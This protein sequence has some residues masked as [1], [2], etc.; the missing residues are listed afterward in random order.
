MLGAAAASWQLGAGCR[1][2]MAFHMLLAAILSLFVATHAAP[3]APEK[4][5]T[6]LKHVCGADKEKSFAACIICIE[7]HLAKIQAH[8]CTSA[9]I[10]KFCN[11]KPPDP[12]AGYNCDPMLHQC[13]QPGNKTKAECGK[14]CGPGPSPPPG[15]GPSPSPMPKG[16]CTTALMRDCEAERRNE[17]AC[18]ACVDKHR[19]SLLKENCT[20]KIVVEFCHATP[21]PSPSPP[22]PPPGP[23]PGPSPGKEKCEK[24]LKKDCGTERSSTKECEACVDAHTK[25]LQKDGCTETDVVRYCKVPVPPGPTP[26]PPPG[27]SGMGTRGMYVTR[28][29][30]AMLT[31]LPRGKKSLATTATA[32]SRLR[33]RDACT[34]AI[35]G[36]CILTYA[37]A[38]ARLELRDHG[39]EMRE[40][41]VEQ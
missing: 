18:E 40:R 33:A 26:P 36:V 10:N 35:N 38:C 23:S 1:R 14:S 28:A 34:L 3:L 11:P 25:S 16:K 9:D 39:Q 21:G 6:Y 12:E 7:N 8:K 32:Y 41:S 24:A 29:P 4:C 13:L 17:E 31:T 30:C 2:M 5:P 19:K 27:P 15:P 37:C 22:S 20:E